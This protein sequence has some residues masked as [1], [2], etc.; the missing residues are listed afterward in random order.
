MRPEI[1]DAM[2]HIVSNA[3]D[4]GLRGDGSKPCKKMN[5]ILAKEASADASINMMARWIISF[6]GQSHAE[7]L[8]NF[9][10][11]LIDTDGTYE[12]RKIDNH[13]GSLINHEIGLME[14]KTRPVRRTIAD[15]EKKKEKVWKDLNQLGWRLYPKGGYDRPDRKEVFSKIQEFKSLYSG[16]DSQKTIEAYH[17]TPHSI[18]REKWPAFASTTVEWQG[19]SLPWDDARHLQADMLLD[20][21]NRSVEINRHRH[22]EKKIGSQKDFFQI[23]ISQHLP[24]FHRFINRQEIMHSMVVRPVM[25]EQ[26]REERYQEPEII[27]DH[28]V[29]QHFRV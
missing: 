21:W 25:D 1:R 7:M 19:K 12:L 8:T 14:D 26:L 18:G 4:Y 17:R 20:Y 2:I 15:L 24:V 29:M 10:Q 13:V 27:S 22:L 3:E 23:F 16:D 6:S 9:L 5:A 28:P 11:R